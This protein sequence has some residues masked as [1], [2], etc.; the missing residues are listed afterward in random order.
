[1]DHFG[2]INCT[3]DASLTQKDLKNRYSIDENPVLFLSYKNS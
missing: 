1:M 3:F 2:S